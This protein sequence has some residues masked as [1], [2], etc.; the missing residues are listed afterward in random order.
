MNF[1]G[2]TREAAG[3][4]FLA[5]GLSAGAAT[6]AA[7]ADGTHEQSL[8]VLPTVEVRAT[9]LPDP[10]GPFPLATTRIGPRTVAAHPGGDLREVLLPLTGLHV[11]SLG[12]PGLGSSVSIRGST[13]AQVLVLVDERRLN[14]TQGGGVDLA[15]IPLE[16]VESVEVFRGGASALWGSDALGGAVHVR[17]KPPHGNAGSLYLG[18]GSHRER[19]LAGTGS[20]A[21]GAGWAARLST[22]LFTTDGDYD[23]VD[24]RRG[25]AATITNGDLRQFSGTLRVEGEASAGLRVR[26]D[27]SALR[28]ERGVP[29]SEEFPTPS[30]R[31]RDDHFD[32]GTRVLRTLSREWQL[33]GDVALLSSRRSYTEPKAAFGPVADSHENT[34]FAAEAG[35]AR[36]GERNALRVQ[37]GYSAD[38]LDSTTDGRRRR[39]AG[40]LSTRFSLDRKL[41]SRSVRWMGAARLDFV[42]GFAPAWSPRLGLLYDA[43]PERLTLRFS[44]GLSYRTPSFDDLFW[45]A[46]ATAAGNPDLKPEHGLDFDAGFT[47]R[48]LPLGARVTGS[49]FTRE[50]RDLIQWAPGAAG[51][52]RPH[53]VGRVRI[54]GVEGETAIL[55]PLPAGA[56]GRLAG[57]AT[58]LE[59]RDCTGEPNVDGRQLVYRPRWS[60]AA[61][62]EVS[63]LRFGTLA[64]VWSF[65]D[66]V[67]VTRANTKIL[68]GYALGEIRYRKSLG[69]LVELDLAVSNVMNRSARDFMNYPLPGRTW[70]MGI[71]VKG[72]D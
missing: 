14:S 48:G 43:A 13:T 5:C 55:L 65:V 22:R 23:Y 34:R 66:D 72:Q 29:G 8:T 9:P 3:A 62:A 26:M 30:A 21:L 31:L 27:A 45:P 59:S 49:G 17:T 25:T 53:N 61:V 33:T 28:G 24:D 42:R 1:A 19:V 50:V 18:G 39:E 38:F 52:W 71:L 12:A 37:A 57:S 15:T 4:C 40:S 63:T 11:T 56:K 46:R 41:A 10:L 58:L 6:G 7:D 44:T 35:M 70:K 64:T 16:M 60:G 54:S 51:I 69:P 68:P 32:W 36:L 67:F 20:L 47:L 2:L